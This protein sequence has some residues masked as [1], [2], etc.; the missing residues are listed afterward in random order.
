MHVD[1]QRG[2]DEATTLRDIL[3]A[4]ATNTDVER[5]ARLI[6]QAALR[7]T[8][9]ATALLFSERT[10]LIEQVSKQPMNSHMPPELS[11]IDITALG[12]GIHHNPAL[13]TAFTTLHPEWI[14]AAFGVDDRNSGE[15]P[16]PAGLALGF[17][18]PFQLKSEIEA[19]LT[20]L[21]ECLM[22]ALK[23]ADVNVRMGL[24]ERFTDA[25][26]SS[27][28]DPIIV[29]DARSSIVT[30]NPAAEK[31]FRVNAGQA[32]GKPLR[33][34]VQADDL[35][36]FVE[37]QEA[38][39]EWS[40][41]DGETFIP[42]VRALDD[43]AGLQSRVLA[44]R[45]ITQ[46]KKL[47]TNQNEF[48][49]NVT[50]DLRSPLTSMQ[51]FASMLELQLVG[52][53]NEKQTHF[54]EKILAGIAQITALVDNIQDAGRFDPETGF[55][56]MT[57]SQCDLVDIVNRIVDN[58]LIPAE[59]QE[60]TLAVVAG[61]NVPV[62]NADTNMLERA[63][64]NLVDNAIKYTPDGGHIDA[65]VECRDKHIYVAVR[66]NGLGISAEHQSR[67]FKRHSRIPREEYKKIKGTGLGLFIVKSVAQRHGGDAWV[68]S[69][70]GKGSMFTI[71]IPLVGPNL[72]VPEN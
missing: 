71:S 6:M 72:L 60:L 13:P 35:L 65:M 41:D 57:R 43:T 66:D 22:T 34:L 59:K 15:S 53:L 50:H 1:T 36:R 32:V 69:E 33:D 46:F 61:D 58:Y 7:A 25:L 68:E 37:G 56:E 54:I 5:V 70:L 17:D 8:S 39:T 63:I 20:V 45:D 10:T 16:L 62:I 40:N 64:Y 67:L 3:H 21:A 19:H 29:F 28:N 23:Q 14:V 47:N 11:L 31:V 42:H 44:L 2:Y 4:L 9:A 38:L 24:A 49:R 48:M 51:G 30:L 55:Y 12:A 27:I 18:G 26:L 52:E